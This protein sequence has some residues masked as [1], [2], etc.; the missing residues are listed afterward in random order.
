MPGETIN[1]KIQIPGKF[2]IT[3]PQNQKAIAVTGFGIWSLIV[4]I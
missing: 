1:P 3:S 2:Q 4:E